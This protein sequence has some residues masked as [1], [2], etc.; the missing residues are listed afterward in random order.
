LEAQPQDIEAV[1][2]VMVSTAA[3]RYPAL[4]LPEAQ[5]A[6][7]Q[8]EHQ[9]ETQLPESA[10]QSTQQTTQQVALVPSAP[11]SPPRPMPKSPLPS[12]FAGATDVIGGVLRQMQQG[13]VPD[14]K[15]RAA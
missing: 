10:Q 2:R 15:F 4:P 13:G 6:E 5:V 7:H 9:A 14:Q 3:L 8:A 12:G 1:P 11:A